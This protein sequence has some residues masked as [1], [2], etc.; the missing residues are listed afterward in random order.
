MTSCRQIGSE[1]CYTTHWS[2][3]SVS[4]L[5]PALSAGT[6]TL[7]LSADGFGA[8]AREV[9]YVLQVTS[10]SATQ[11]S[12]KGGTL[13]RLDGTGFSSDCSR[14]KVK[15]GQVYECEVLQCSDEALTCI[16]RPITTNHR[17]V[18][19]GTSSE[20]VSWYPRVLEVVEGDSVTWQ[21]SKVSENSQLQY[22]VCEVASPVDNCEDADGSGFFSGTQTAAGSFT[23][24]FPQQGIH[25]YAGPTLPGGVVMRGQ[26]NVVRPPHQAL[27]MAVLLGDKEATYQVAGSQVVNMSG[28]DPILEMPL[29]GCDLPDL[30]TPENGYLYFHF[31]TCHTPVVSAL[32]SSTTHTVKGLSGLQVVGGDSLTI[33]G[34][35]FGDLACQVEV[36]VGEASCSVT[37]AS[38]TSVTCDLDDLDNL[39]SGAY[40][41]ITVKA[42]NR[43]IA[44]TDIAGYSSEGRVVVVPQVSSLSPLEGSLGGSTL[45]T[46]S[47]S[48]LQGLVASPVVLVGG[49]TCVVQ[50]VSS[51]TV[52]CL[53]PPSTSA[54]VATFTLTVAGVPAKMDTLTFTYSEALTPVVT[55][56]AVQ[57]EEVTLSGHNFGSDN[58][59]VTI[60][61]VQQS[62]PHGCREVPQEEEKEDLM[63]EEREEW[64]W[65][66]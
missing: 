18:N 33:T 56:M 19:V 3:I 47:G 44:V 5:T 14:L 36:S 2:N 65:W 41:P 54:T 37:S 46:I 20:T 11:G 49:Q 35:G 66:C 64:W 26:V 39:R 53:T 21:W 22:G 38:D 16:T 45:L 7:V 59:K 4:C 58:T 32:A 48:S 8:A 6:H 61:L 30:T 27:R 42:I 9:E 63:V 40:L 10:A 34:S 29:D 31:H 17:I 62:V 28:C 57:G 13:V 25:Y 43:G 50:S 55:S 1:L 51:T 52:T 15:L 24:A 23:V 60:T 12:V